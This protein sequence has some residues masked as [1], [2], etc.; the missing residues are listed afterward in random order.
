[1]DNIAEGFERDGHKE[2]MQFLY[3]SKGSNAETRS[4]SYR[5]I[6]A[7]FITQEE[8]ED[9]LKRTSSIKNKIQKLITY[10]KQNKQKGR[11]YK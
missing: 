7:E 8:F 4:Q 11:K 10:L 1:M 5:A 6:D 3:I 2:F 9:I